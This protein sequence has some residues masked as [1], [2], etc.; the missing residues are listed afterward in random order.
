MFGRATMSGLLYLER[1]DFL[2]YQSECHKKAREEHKA[3]SERMKKRFDKQMKVK[4]C[5]LS[6]GDKVLFKRD[7]ISK[8]ISNCNPNPF[9]IIAVKGFF[10][11][12]NRIYPSSSCF[13]LFGGPEEN[14]PVISEQTMLNTYGKNTLE[15][16]ELHSVAEF[17]DQQQAIEDTVQTEELQANEADQMSQE[18]QG[19]EE[20]VSTI[21]SYQKELI[22]IPRIMLLKF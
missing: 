15:S 1:F 21:N 12:A 8:D 7:A 16:S 17:G 20:L 22:H 11:T 19:I 2:A 4:D 18:V 9:T 6:S 5:P 14:E 3:Y 13:K 10:V